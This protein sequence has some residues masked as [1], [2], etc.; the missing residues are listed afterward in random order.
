MPG[1]LEGG[2]GCVHNNF[3]EVERMLD[4]GMDVNARNTGGWLRLCA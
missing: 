4:E 1:T 3:V 2:Q